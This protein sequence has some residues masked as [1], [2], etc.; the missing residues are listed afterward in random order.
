MEPHQDGS[1]SE[2]MWAFPFS[3]GPAECP[4]LNRARR[5]D[6][7]AVPDLCVPYRHHPLSAVVL[8]RHAV[9]VHVAHAGV[10]FGA[11]RE[12]QWIVCRVPDRRDAMQVVLRV[13]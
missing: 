10:A 6:H 1:L 4:T 3:V 13:V 12:E 2:V 7:L 11:T 5:D 8:R 9:F